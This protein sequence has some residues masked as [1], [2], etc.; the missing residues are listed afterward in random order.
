MCFA[1]SSSSSPPLISS[2][3]P[4]PLPAV[5][6]NLGTDDLRECS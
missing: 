1:S 6:C 3:R 2:E 4:Q 5:E